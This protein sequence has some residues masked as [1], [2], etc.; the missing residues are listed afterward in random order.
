MNPTWQYPVPMS[1]LLMNDKFWGKTANWID[2]VTWKKKTIVMM[3]GQ[4][5]TLY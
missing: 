2:I 4:T 1:I 5:Y 3:V